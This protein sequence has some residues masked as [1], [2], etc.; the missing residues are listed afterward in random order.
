LEEKI[1]FWIPTDILEDKGLINE[2][3]GSRETVL[4]Q[5]SYPECEEEVPLLMSRHG[6]PIRAPTRLNL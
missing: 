5:P 6:R 3:D 4:I 2:N 1:K